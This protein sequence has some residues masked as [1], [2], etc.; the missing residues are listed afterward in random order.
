MLSNGGAPLLATGSFDDA[1]PFGKAFVDGRA[2]PHDLGI[3]L[4]ACALAQAAHAKRGELVELLYRYVDNDMDL[5]QKI[6][7]TNPERL[8]GF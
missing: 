2:R 3:G 7:V 4:A 8:H 1:V 6:L 5:I